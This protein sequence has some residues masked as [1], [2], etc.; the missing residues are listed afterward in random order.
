MRI[1]VVRQADISVEEG[2]L[3]AD[4]EDHVYVQ[5]DGDVYRLSGRASS[6][7]PDCVYEAHRV[8]N[9]LQVITGLRWTEYRPSRPVLSGD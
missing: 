2:D 8:D 1:H 7:T 5:H 3:I 4:G 6:I 9:P